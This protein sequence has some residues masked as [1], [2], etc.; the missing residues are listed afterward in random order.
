MNSS[1]CPS[2]SCFACRSRDHSPWC[3]LTGDALAELD[4][5]KLPFRYKPGQFLFFEGDPCRGIY[6]IDSGTVALRRVGPSESE[7]VM[8]LCHPGDTL[9]YGAFLADSD[10]RN[11]AEATTECQV[12]YID[13]SILKG[14]IE[15]NP[16]VAHRF[17]VKMAAKIDDAEAMLVSCRTLSVRARLANTLLLLKDRYASADEEGRLTFELPFSRG[18]LASLVGT[19]PES[20]SRAIRALDLAGV[21]KFQGRNVLVHDLDDLLDEIENDSNGA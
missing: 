1:R 19:R 7:S 5:A 21:A 13:G 8:G 11:T 20:L 2:T 18:L 15:K 14:V 12:C 4:Q 6:C 3:A 10:H 9:G 17:L 16:A